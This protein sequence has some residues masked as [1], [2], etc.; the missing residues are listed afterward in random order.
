MVPGWHHLKLY[1]LKPCIIQQM[2]R[3]FAAGTRHVQPLDRVRAHDPL[4]PELRTKNQS[5]KHNKAEQSKNEH[6]FML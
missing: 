4:D 6:G 2:P 3:Q 5:D 1:V